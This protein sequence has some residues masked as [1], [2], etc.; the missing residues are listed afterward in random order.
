MFELLYV[1][2]A[3]YTSDPSN[4]LREFHIELCCAG[5]DLTARRIT[6]EGGMLIAYEILDYAVRPL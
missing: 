3:N 5:F 4:G 1:A 2:C 6:N